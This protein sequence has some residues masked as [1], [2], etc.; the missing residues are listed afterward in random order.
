MQLAYRNEAGRK[1]CDA[2]H[3]ARVWFVAG[4]KP[5]SRAGMSQGFDF[6][7]TAIAPTGGAT[8]P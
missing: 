3:R 5:V 7:S 2:M 4:V 8:A 6:V 1:A